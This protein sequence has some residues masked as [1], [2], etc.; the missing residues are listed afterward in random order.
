M[1]RLASC[2]MFLVIPVVLSASTVAWSGSADDG[3]WREINKEDGVVVFAEADPES[4][5]VALR[6]TSRVWAPIST[7]YE[8]L[9][10]NSTAHLWMPMVMKK[11]TLKDI[12]KLTRIE[13]TN[14]DFPW[15]CDDRYF[16][17]QGWTEWRKDGS[18]IVTMHS[19][20]HPDHSDESKV[21][22]VFHRSVVTLVPS[23]KG[24]AT[25]M[26]VEVKTDP[27]G[28]IPTWLVN[29]AQ[30]SWP[31]KFFNGLNGELSRR[32]ALQAK[33]LAH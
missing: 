33:P 6:G 27:K 28:W 18:I 31:V 14:V 19:V 21:L 11:G 13:Y 2:V 5:I 32:R 24:M 17:A 7:V 29:A 9:I 23:E 16:I 4:E 20:D 30:R 22:G 10:D 12:S 1:M 3:H 26:T 25:A 8:T 15:P